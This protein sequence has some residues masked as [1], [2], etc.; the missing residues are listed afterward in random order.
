MAARM[1]F[2]VYVDLTRELAMA[3]RSALASTLDAHVS[4][5]GCVGRHRGSHDEVYFS[6]EADRQDDAMRLACEAIRACLLQARIE[7]H[8]TI[9]VV[10]ARH[11]HRSTPPASDAS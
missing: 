2:D 8:Y 3:E 4:G 7:A 1:I 10:A 5:G 6:V 9:E 11:A